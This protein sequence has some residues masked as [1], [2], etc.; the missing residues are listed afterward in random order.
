MPGER[1]TQLLPQD[2]TGTLHAADFDVAGNLIRAY[3]DSNDKLVFVV[4]STINAAKPNVL[5]VLNAVADRKWDDILVNDYGVDLEFVRPKKDNKYQK[6]DIEYSGLA[7]Y[8]N[9]LRAF[10]A[11]DDMADALVALGRFRA[12]SARRAATER[13]AAAESTADK[14]RET[15]EKTNDTITDIQ[16]RVKELRAKL[17]QQRKAVGKEPTKQSAAKIL[18]TEAQL[19]ASN[20][21]MRRAKKRLANARRRLVVAEEDAA[22]ARKILDSASSG[23]LVPVRNTP[24]APVRDAPSAVVPVFTDMFNDPD[25][26]EL[27]ISEIEEEPKAEKMAE[28]EV[29]PLLDKDP[30]ILDE[31]IAF[32]P[33]DFDVPAVAPVTAPAPVARQA[34]DTPVAPAP[35][36]FTPPTTPQSR[37]VAQI[38]SDAPQ[39][40]V[41]D[42][43]TPIAVPQV[44]DVVVEETFTPMPVEPVAPVVEEEVVVPVA[45]V[46]Q[47]NA[48]PEIVPAP[49]SS[50]LRPTSPITNSG[51]A[52]TPAG[53]AGR[54]KPTLIYYLMLVALIVLSIFTLWLYQKSANQSVPDLG[55]VSQPEV[56]AAPVA[57]A[58]VLDDS[59]FLDATVETVSEPEPA[60]IA[61]PEP[62]AEQEVVVEEETV[63]EQVDVEPEPVP[64]TPEPEPIPEP[65][66]AM[67]EI[68]E[69]PF[70]DD[71]Q[72][73]AEPEPIAD[74][75]SEPVVD[76][77]GV[78]AADPIVNKPAYNVSQQ[79]NMFIADD[80]Y[81]NGENTGGQDELYED[82]YYEEDTSVGYPNADTSDY[83][84]ETDF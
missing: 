68:P 29:K 4:D 18:R 40:P 39:A 79:E 56:A 22:A 41:L 47:Q 5:L 45:P 70:L 28:D 46:A 20:E 26:E 17:S 21:K 75:E 13:L 76:Q 38:P 64:V 83:Y 31:E 84:Y 42:T 32:K 52:V 33:I 44:E 81:D 78:P 34:A 73:V 60:P 30:E 63:I 10:N 48:M 37:D 58:P 82:T 66:P 80:E 7:E 72:P 51:V 77:D 55:A 12:M 54:N 8:D 9:L 1:E 67:D 27:V 3:F 25:D 16:A 43:I 71:V 65:N 15:I 74:I 50:D 11:G 6:L 59:P 53:G 35:L 62:V 14:A 49:A 36:S 24:P 57:P 69:N 19:D 2:K 23:D 61:E